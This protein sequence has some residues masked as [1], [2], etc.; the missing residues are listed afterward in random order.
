MTRLVQMKMASIQTTFEPVVLVT[1]SSRFEA[2][3]DTQHHSQVR[4]RSLLGLPILQVPHIVA[5]TIAIPG[6]Y[7]HPASS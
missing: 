7:L 5:S 4:E 3:Y 6:A 2:A 1:N